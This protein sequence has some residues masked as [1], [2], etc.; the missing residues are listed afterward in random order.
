M[1]LLAVFA[2]VAVL[3]SAIGIYGVIAYLVGQRSREIGIRLALGASQTTVIRMI[4]LDGA[5]MTATG[6]G[7][8][9]VGAF[10]L[11]RS[12]TALLFDVKPSDPMTYLV[13]TA[14]LAAVALAASCI[15]ALRAAHVDPALTMRAE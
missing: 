4:A 12:M 7:V 5:I 3:L 9:L 8:G 13:V 15:P 14:L 11:T 1:V 2:G 6:I 10:A